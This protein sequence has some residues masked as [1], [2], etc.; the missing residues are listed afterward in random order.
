LLAGYRI[1]AKLYP[2]S[3]LGTHAQ[4]QKVGALEGTGFV[5]GQIAV[6]IGDTTIPASQ[7]DVAAD[8]TLLTFTTPPGVAG[9]VD[10]V[11]P[12]RMGP[13]KAFA[14]STVDTGPQLFVFDEP[15]A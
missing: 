7:V 6:M 2:Q 5:P 3:S 8:G 11:V 4:D 9:T 12:P 10:V 14:A 13:L 15:A 1:G